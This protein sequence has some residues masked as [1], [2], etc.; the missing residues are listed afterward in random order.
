MF[1]LLSSLQMYSGLAAVSSL[2]QQQKKTIAISRSAP[3]HVD[4][5]KADAML[6]S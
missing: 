2:H 1:F 6:F 5:R 4:I 3:A